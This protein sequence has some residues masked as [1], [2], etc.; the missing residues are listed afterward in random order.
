MRQDNNPPIPVMHKTKVAGA[1]TALTD[2]TDTTDTD[3]NQGFAGPIQAIRSFVTVHPSI[4]VDPIDSV[5]VSS[6]DATYPS[7]E[8]AKQAKR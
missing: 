7:R 2:T 4:A 5:I 6:G 1:G 3:K 8:P